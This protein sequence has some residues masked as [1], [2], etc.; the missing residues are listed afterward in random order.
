MLQFRSSHYVFRVSCCARKRTFSLKAVVIDL[1]LFA[2][3]ENTTPPAR[4]VDKR[5]TPKHKT[6][7]IEGVTDVLTKYRARLREK[8]V[9]QSSLTKPSAHA[10][11]AQL[12]QQVKKTLSD[13]TEDSPITAEMETVLNYLTHRGLKLYI[14]AFNGCSS[15]DENASKALLKALRMKSPPLNILQDVEVDEAV[16]KVL[17]N[18][19]IFPSD[20][21]IFSDQQN[22]L[23]LSKLKK[24]TTCRFGYVFISLYTTFILFNY[25]K[26]FAE[27]FKNFIAIV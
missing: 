4:I 13:C 26:L 8:N 20:M 21:I 24:I 2:K 9:F 10:G 17:T 19:K 18:H 11:D 14:C 16:D 25:L 3:K 7:E 15:L 1:S 5:A 22:V 6:I 23:S 27:P 12:L